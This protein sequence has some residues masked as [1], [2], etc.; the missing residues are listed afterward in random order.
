MNLPE[1]VSLTARTRRYIRVL[2]TVTN[3][4]S[5]CNALIPV[6]HQMEINESESSSMPRTYIVRLE[7]A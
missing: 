4:V 5:A 3:V 6:H 1:I 2:D 7:H